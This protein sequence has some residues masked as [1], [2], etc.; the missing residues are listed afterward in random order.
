MH[1][2]IIGNGA[3]GLRTAQTIRKRDPEGAITMVDEERHPS[4]YRM[5][6]PDYISGW[7]GRE[8]V[9]AVEDGFYDENRIE[10]R[11][12]DR[13]VEVRPDAHEVV[14]EKGGTL[15]YDRL[16]IAAGAR[17]RLMSCGGHE[18]D[19]VVYLRTLDQ[20]EEIIARARTAKSAVA[21]G[22]GL[23]GVEMARCFNELGL[24]THYLIREDRF[25]PQ[26]LDAAGSSLVE[27]VLAEKGIRLLKEE[28][29]DEITGDGTRVTGVRT[30]SGGRLDAD[31][32]G[33]AIGV[34][35]NLEFL[36]GSGIETDRGILTDERLRA[37][38]PDIFAAGDAAQ[39]LDP[40][41]GEHRLVTSY[42]NTQ[43]QGEVAGTNMSGGDAA[44]E[45]IVPFNVIV[46]Y[47]LPVA[48]MGLDLPPDEEGYEVLTG[49][50][51]R[52]GQYRKLVLSRGALV[53]ATLIGNIGE[54]Q[55]I[56]SL[57]RMRADVSSFRDR[58]FEPGFDA[59]RVL[60]EI[61]GGG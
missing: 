43:R 53:G 6:L 48:S 20:A 59:R 35:S 56:E 33:I 18:L 5:R 13:A 11:R 58:L 27:K 12:E 52:D 22:G 8:T 47:G 31:M 50:F 44:M 23:L 61:K 37:S 25:W 10:L 28:G 38:K 7:K 55:A 3:A 34:V 21:L 32:V 49:D 42:L 57:I 36:A 17:P 9:F 4:Y 39:V 30:T 14:L 51:P 16:L 54:A 19:G 1:Y 26:M 45:G 2:L 40:A 24:T 60:K 41:S 15:P 29:I 46:I